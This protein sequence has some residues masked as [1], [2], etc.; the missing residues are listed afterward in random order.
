[1]F[2]IQLYDETQ[3]FN[4]FSPINPIC[5][6]LAINY[7]EMPC[8]ECCKMGSHAYDNNDYI[9]P[10]TSKENKCKCNEKMKISYIF[11][12][13]S[14]SDLNGNPYEKTYTIYFSKATVNHDDF[15]ESLNSIDDMPN[16]QVFT[17]Q[18]TMDQYDDATRETIKKFY[19]EIKKFNSELK[20]NTISE[21][22]LPRWFPCG[23][24]KKTDKFIS[25]YDTIIN[26]ILAP[27]QKAEV[28]ENPHISHKKGA[29]Q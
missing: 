21:S 20:F 12:M 10:F 17:I 27:T 8:S 3:Y 22:W 11:M 23:D 16:I 4:V 5:Y 6:N 25:C 2:S 13:I 28:K 26:E 15:I 14:V 24:S 18:K 1:M 19:D 7:N 9:L 29:K